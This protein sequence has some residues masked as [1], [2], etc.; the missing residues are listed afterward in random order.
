VRQ[1]FGEILGGTEF[2]KIGFFEGKFVEKIQEI[3][4]RKNWGEVLGG[5][6]EKLWARGEKIFRAEIFVRKISGTK[7]SRGAGHFFGEILEKLF[8]KIS[9]KIPRGAGE[10]ILGKKFEEFLDGEKLREIFTK[11]FEVENFQ[12]KNL[13]FFWSGKFAR[14]FLKRN[15]EKIWKKSRAGREKN[16]RFN[17]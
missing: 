13:R 1:K 15:L 2:E 8:G 17:F 6:S 9:G 5:N 14:K 12:E 10:K 4:D 7:K 11:V 16:L 3:L